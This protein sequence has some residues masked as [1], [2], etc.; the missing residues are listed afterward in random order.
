MSSLKKII[1]QVTHFVQN[2]SIVYCAETKKCA[3][4]DP[5]GDIEILLEKA[6]Q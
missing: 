3:F 1:D 5:G 4:V 2:A 6:K